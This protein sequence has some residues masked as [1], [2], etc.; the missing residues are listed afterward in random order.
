MTEL[1]ALCS[2][3]QAERNPYAHHK[4]CT[5]SLLAGRAGQQIPTAETFK[6]CRL[7][8]RK[9]VTAVGGE[10]RGGFKERGCFSSNWG[11]ITNFAQDIRSH[12]SLTETHLSG[13]G[14]KSED[15]PIITSLKVLF[16]NLFYVKDLILKDKANR[17]GIPNAA[18]PLRF[19]ELLSSF[20]SLFW[21]YGPQ[22]PPSILNYVQQQ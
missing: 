10:Q 9:D 6:S 2:L 19:M 17:E 16:I 15:V 13:V 22:T 21:F 3:R 8:N 4:D 14:L 20:S 11:P 1:T 5:I 12:K 7:Q 18:A